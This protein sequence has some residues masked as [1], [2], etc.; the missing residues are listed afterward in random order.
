MAKQHNRR[1]RKKLHL[2]EFQELGF[3]V[4]AV[5]REGVSEADAERVC[6]A[7]I[8]DCIE[9]A[10]LTYGGA[11]GDKLDGFVVPFA[12]LAS[13]TESHR[14]VVRDWLEARAE[15]TSVEVGPLV[16]AWY[17]HD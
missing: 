5:L 8:A 14:A 13:A 2:G 10:Q 7:F 6:D 12:N 16:D 15:L 17:G 1:Q 4:S 3:A 11:I 9:D